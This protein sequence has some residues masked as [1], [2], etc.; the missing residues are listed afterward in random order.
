LGEGLAVEKIISLFVW[1]VANLRG[2]GEIKKPSPAKERAELYEF[3]LIRLN[4]YECMC[5]VR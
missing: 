3:Y 1:V 4:F 5:S 2:S